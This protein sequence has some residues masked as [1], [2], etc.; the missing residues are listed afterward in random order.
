MVS[1]DQIKKNL[2]YLKHIP[3]FKCILDLERVLDSKNALMILN[4]NTQC[5]LMQYWLIDKILFFI[6]ICKANCHIS[7]FKQAIEN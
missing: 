5:L 4:V 2:N 6:K 1:G 3:N 7:G